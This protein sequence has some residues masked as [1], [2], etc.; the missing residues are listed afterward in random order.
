MSTEQE[1]DYLR[2]IHEL[3]KQIAR[4]QTE[5]KKNSETQYGL[6]WM[7]VPEAFEA[8]AENAIPTLEEVK[9]KAITNDDGKP[10]HILIEGDNFHALTCLNYTHKGNIDVIYID[11]PYNTG[12]DGFVYKDKRV[13]D[14]FPDGT[15]VP[16]DH[17]L[18]HSYWLSFMHKRLELAKNLLSE[19]GVIFISIDDNEQANLKLLCDQ[20]FGEK[21]FV[22]NF[23]WRGGRRNMAKWIST[24]HEYMLMYANDL[25]YCDRTNIEWY[26][27]KRGLDAIYKE[28]EFCVKT[29]NGDYEEASAML[30]KWYK[31]LSPDNP[32]KDHEHYCW[33][34]KRGVYF[35]ADISRGGG[36]GPQ[37]SITNPYTGEIVKTPQ[38]GWAYSTIEELQQDI[39]SDLIHFNGS[40]VPCRKHYLKDSETQ[41]LETVFYKDRR[42]SSKR[43]RDLMGN[44]VFSF[45]K[46]ETI[47]REKL[48][49]F[50]T[51]SSIILDFF[52]GSGTTMHA[53]M[54]LNEEDGGHRQ[55]ILA[56]Q[57]ENNICEAVTYERN[58]R[59]MQ[60]YTN[61]KGEAIAGLGNS[62]KYYR[63]AFVGEHK[64]TDITDADKVALTQKA[65]CLLALGENTLE[66]IRTAKSYQIF[67]LRKGDKPTNDFGYTAVYFSGNLMHFAEFRREIERIQQEQPLSRIAVYVFTWG[68]PSIFENEFDDLSGITIKPIPQPILE[69][70]QNI[71]K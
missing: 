36:G 9:E 65:G 43:L 61:A 41:I 32:S 11:P 62:M 59:V 40:G 45:P 58:K 63:T 19:R 42:A 46:D 55:C 31:S 44:D 66:E 29:A 22:A 3:E 30:K 39:A 17:P 7:D 33:I 12:S 48:K 5:I 56:Q 51:P 15:T 53:T 38:R 64:I 34:D 18:R 24:S 20:V 13:M 10:T 8:E 4:L 16:S 60:G 67:Q 57:N 70:Y 26:E 47:I 28:A 14:K 1:N 23:I 71:N 21:N 68:D 54:Q 2:R 52:A 6:R 27:K 49:S 37:W 35:A 25:G 69:I 50:S